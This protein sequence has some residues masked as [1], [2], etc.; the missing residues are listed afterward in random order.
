MPWPKSVW[1]LLECG[2]WSLICSR[3][4]VSGTRERGSV[5][6]GKVGEDKITWN[7]RPKV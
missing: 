2:E 7:L 3:T 5:V 4:K 6:A 1:R